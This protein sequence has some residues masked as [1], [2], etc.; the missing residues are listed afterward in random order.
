MEKKEKTKLKI[1]LWTFAICFIF[2]GIYFLTLL[3]FKDFILEQINKS[4]NFIAWFFTLTLGAMIPG[5]IYKGGDGYSKLIKG[6]FIIKEKGFAYHFLDT[7]LVTL[8]ILLSGLLFSWL[9]GF[10]LEYALII[11]IVWTL[12]FYITYCRKHDY[13][14]PWLYFIVINLINLFWGFMIY[15]FI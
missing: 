4:S 13:K 10:I 5:L 1:Y 9:F 11:L 12:I 6:K 15:R 3:F 14:F 8:I 7:F 2:L